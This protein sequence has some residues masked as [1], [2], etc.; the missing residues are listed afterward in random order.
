MHDGDERKRHT[1]FGLRINKFRPNVPN[2]PA[3][4]TTAEQMLITNAQSAVVIR[5]RPLPYVQRECA[6]LNRGQEGAAR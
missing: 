3:S 6:T 1:H 4:D 2:N 5:R